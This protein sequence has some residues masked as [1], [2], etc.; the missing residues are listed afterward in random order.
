MRNRFL[1][2]LLVFFISLISAQQ[3]PAFWDEVQAFKAED[4]LSTPPEKSIL[5]LGSSSL[6]LWKDIALYF[7]GKTFVNR[8]FGGARLADMNI[9]AKDILD[10]YQPGK[11]LIYGGENDVVYSDF[12][13][14]TMIFNRYKVFYKEIRKRFPDTEVVYISMK[15]SP[16]RKEFWPVMKKANNK[17]E[18]FMRQEKN[19][20]YIDITQAMNLNGETRTD[21][22]LED[23]LHMKPEGY[24]IW[25]KAIAP[26]L[27]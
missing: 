27:D 4:R 22:F 23:M 6:R 26:F 13:S 20:E 18:H 16:S 14:A 2:V 3:K 7:P 1:T 15:Y 19:A 24:E 21:L 9:Y 5:L 25:A 17:I 11:I 12:P 10:P 8:A